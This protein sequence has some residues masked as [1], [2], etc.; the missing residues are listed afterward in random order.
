M[1][2]LRRQ[3]WWQITARG[4]ETLPFTLSQINVICISLAPE[5][6]NRMMKEV[7]ICLF[8]RKKSVGK[9]GAGWGGYEDESVSWGGRQRGEGR[10]GETL[11]G[12]Q[13][14][15][16]SN[17]NRGALHF[18][19]PPLN[20]VRRPKLLTSLKPTEQSGASLQSGPVAVRGTDSRDNRSAHAG[21]MRRVYLG[22]RRKSGASE[23]SNIKGISAGTDRREEGGG[24]WRGGRRAKE[25]E[26]ETHLN[27][28][29][30]FFIYAVC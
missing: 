27:F 17:R 14:W 16:S 1:E 19:W 10:E 15:I 11:P 4:R 23:G 2:P 20:N 12:G 9:R 21:T 8:L 22:E 7:R 24:G 13:R 30:F 29:H 25:E 28:P 3:K 18:L 5:G 6:P 26:E